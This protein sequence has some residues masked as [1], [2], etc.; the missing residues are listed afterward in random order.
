[1]RSFLPSPGTRPL[2]PSAPCSPPAEDASAP[3]LPSRPL[4]S[5]VEW[6][7]ALSLM[8]VCTGSW[9]YR[10]VTPCL[11]NFVFLLETRF[12]HVGE[13]SLQLPTLIDPPALASQSAGITVH[14]S[15]ISC[16]GLVLGYCPDTI[17]ESV[18]AQSL[19]YNDAGLA[20]LPRQ[21]CSGMT[22]AHCTLDLPG[23]KSPL[24]IVEAGVQLVVQSQLTA[25]ST[26][27]VQA[28]LVP[29]CPES[30]WNTTRECTSPLELENRIVR[31]LAFSPINKISDKGHHSVAQAGVQWR[32][33]GSLQTPPP[34]FREA[35]LLPQLL[36]ELWSENWGL[37]RSV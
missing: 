20:L 24:L 14:S 28:F 35:I 25:T 2:P 29:Q 8:L 37:Y 19:T 26:S 18:D 12:H 22:T 10:C 17:P 16:R 30:I 6:S 11:A 32:N 36:K 33:L 3:L 34:R 4:C 21:E 15:L 7:L 27:Q 9:N 13:V 1:M 31:F 5:T 23:S